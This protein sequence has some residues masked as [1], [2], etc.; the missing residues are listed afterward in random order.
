[1]PFDPF[2]RLQFIFKE[3]TGNLL[4]KHSSGS[5]EA[6]LEEFARA[7][8][9]RVEEYLARLES[10]ADVQER[11]RLIERL[12][13][14]TTWFL[15]EADGL[16]KL[17]AALK[18]N[19]KKGAKV[20]V[21]GCSTGEEPYS[22]AMVLRDA[23]VDADIL[24]TDISQVALK[25]AMTAVYNVRAIE[26]LPAD[27]RRRYFE[28][29]GH[30]QVRVAPEVR[31]R[32][33]FAQH[34]L[35]RSQRPPPTFGRPDAL[36]CRNMLFYFERTDAVRIL[37]HFHVLIPDAERVVLGASEQLLDWIGKPASAWP[38]PAILANN[39]FLGE[40]EISAITF[41]VN[42]SDLRLEPEPETRAPP[43]NELTIAEAQF[44]GGDLADA[45]RTLRKILARDPLVAR[46]HLIL[47]LLLKRI[48]EIRDAAASFRSARMLFSD[49]AWLPPYELGRCL[50]RLG[51]TYGALEAYRHALAVIEA[52]GSSGMPSE[53]QLEDHAKTAG[54]VCMK[55]IVNLTRLGI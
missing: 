1:M 31:A 39:S 13:N 43:A 12:L 4:A 54:E 40:P 27:W 28:P 9:M 35:A 8:G 49:E 2:D 55:R 38:G 53:D 48:G 51:E 34:N 17:A 26:R 20:W 3:W 21:V 37:H 22:L 5:A 14:R 47:G 10:G 16:Q 50:D 41:A 33:S 7:R 23:A 45:H 32:V 15:R 25:T 30:D 19:P 44:R 11:E 18:K 46:A 42:S 29:V 6:S 36:L 24:A 52:H